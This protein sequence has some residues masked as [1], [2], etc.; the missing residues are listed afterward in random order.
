MATQLMLGRIMG[1]STQF[2]IFSPNIYTRVFSLRRLS[3]YSCAVINAISFFPPQKNGGLLHFN[4]FQVSFACPELHGPRHWARLPRRVRE[5]GNPA[6]LIRRWRR[7]AG[8]PSSF[9]GGKRRIFNPFPQ[10]VYL[11][12]I[13]RLSRLGRRSPVCRLTGGLHGGAGPPWKAVTRA[14]PRTSSGTPPGPPRPPWA[15]HYRWTPAGRPR[16]CGPSGCRSRRPWRRP[17]HRHPAPCWG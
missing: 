6:R 10:G 8:F 5:R 9:A 1:W 4:V 17:P 7:F 13:P 14:L 11:P 3:T 12:K 2:S 15:W 16:S